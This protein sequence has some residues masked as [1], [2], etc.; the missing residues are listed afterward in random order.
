MD[1]EE[2]ETERTEHDPARCPVGL[3][4]HDAIW[5][6]SIPEHESL[7]KRAC[8]PECSL[9]AT[10]TDGDLA[11]GDGHRVSLGSVC[12]AGEGVICASI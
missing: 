10:P 5:E 4:F 3:I 11:C 1:K 8:G 2:T 12:T 6:A 9:G 7:Q